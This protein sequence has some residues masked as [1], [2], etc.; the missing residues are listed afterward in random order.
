MS[1]ST[2]TRD[3]GPATSPLPSR[4]DAAA[5]EL[6]VSLQMNGER[7]QVACVDATRRYAATDPSATLPLNRVTS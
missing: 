7:A 6:L 2:P 3:R 1:E 4:L 5:A